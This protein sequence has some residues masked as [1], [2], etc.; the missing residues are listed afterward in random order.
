MKIIDKI[1]LVPL[2]I[3]SLL[4]IGAPFMPEPHL[5]EKYGMLMSGKLNKMMDLFDVVWHLLP[6]MILSIKVYFTFQRK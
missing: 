2:I 1:P 6:A 5:V 4:M 3:I